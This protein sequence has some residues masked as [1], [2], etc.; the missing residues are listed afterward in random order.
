[1]ARRHCL[2]SVEPPKREKDA[3]DGSEH[4][5]DRA[6]DKHLLG[7]LAA[8]CAERGAHSQFAF[9]TE[10]ARQLHVCDVGA[11]DEKHTGD[12]CQEQCHALFVILHRRI[13]KDQCGDAAS[14]VGIGIA[15]FELS[16]D[17]I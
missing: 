11:G 14:C 17:G 16:G 2:D 12:C 7:E 6:F 1:M 13:E 3:S 15:T 10:R 4:G 5:Q 8:A 9:A